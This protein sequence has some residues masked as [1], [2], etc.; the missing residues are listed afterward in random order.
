MRP[1]ASA[2]LAAL[3]L[4]GA[5]RAQDSQPTPRPK[6]AQVAPPQSKAQVAPPPLSREDKELVKELA[7]LE[8]ME[9]VKNLELF[10]P[11]PDAA[12]EEPQRQP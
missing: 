10:Q 3:A 2:V 8:Q 12:R 5:A 6:M 4:A 7:L 1:I 9:L 11:E